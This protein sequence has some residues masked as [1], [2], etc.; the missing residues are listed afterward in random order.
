MTT[1]IL[2]LLLGFYI[3]IKGSD[4]LI[5][6]SASIARKL[7]VSS[8]IIGITIVGFGTST[9]ELITSLIAAWKGESNIVLGN[10][11]GSN[12][13]NIGLILGVAALIAPLAIKDITLR[14]ELPFTIVASVAMLV[15]MFDDVF[16]GSH[17]YFSRGDGIILLIFLGIF[18]YYTLFS[19]SAERAKT[20]KLKKEVKEVLDTQEFETANESPSEISTMKAVNYVVLGLIGLVGGGTLVVSNAVFIAESI[21]LSKTF[22]GLTVIALGTSLPE[23]VTSAVAAYKK[24][25]DVAIGNIVGSNIFNLLA[26]LSLAATVS[27]FEINN[28]T[29]VDALIMTGMMIVLFLFGFTKTIGR[30]AGVIFLILYIA[31]MV[32]I[33]YR[34]INGIELF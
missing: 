25:T 16:N 27:P 30:F 17:N 12:I 26:V 14:R 3:L 1:A 22:I 29:I 13:A 2:I 20:Q 18:I 21:G 6:G 33:S 23:L 31:S 34:D 32:F 5:D 4:L 10:V 15:L 19:I 9:P 8:L 11:I 7:G 28:N 24:E